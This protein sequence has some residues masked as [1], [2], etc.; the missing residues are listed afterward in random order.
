MLI[1][2]NQVVL[3]YY[4]V[5]DEQGNEVENF[6]GGE[7]NVYLYGYGGIIKGLEEVLEGCE[8]GDIFSVI[9]G[10]EKVY[11]LCKEDVIQCV[12]I[13]YLMGVKCWKV[14]MIV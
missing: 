3:F 10:L 9:V 13:K 2:K 14:G 5:C 11:G 12:L 6:Y 8:V 4:S 7:F 1:E